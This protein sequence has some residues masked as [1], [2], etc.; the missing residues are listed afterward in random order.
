MRRRKERGEGEERKD[1]ECFWAL[2]FVPQ[3]LY[4]GDDSE[5]T[6]NKNFPNSKNKLSI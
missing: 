6:K 3:S 5:E 1:T 2:Y 4:F